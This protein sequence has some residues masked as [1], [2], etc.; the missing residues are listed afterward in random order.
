MKPLPNWAI[1]HVPHNS[2]EI[3]EAVRDQF[4]LSDL[5]LQNE[6]LKMTDHHTL[7]L[8]TRS[9]PTEQVVE[10]KVSRL[11]V[12]VERFE[13]DA[14]EVMTARGMGVI[15][16]KRHDGQPMRRN[17]SNDE[18]EQL[19]AEW[20]RPHHLALTAVVDKSIQRYGKALVIDAHSFPLLP[21]PYELDHKASRPEICIGADE[22][23]TP[24]RL[25]NAMAD[26]FIG[27]GFKVGINTPFSG[28]IVP[29]SHYQLDP[30]VLA[31][32][33]E[34]RRD[35]YMNEETGLPSTDF[36]RIA[37]EIQACISSSICEI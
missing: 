6:L 23:H 5:E 37:T 18:R 15:Y 21:L 31:V 22:F 30:R 14:Q 9:L 16:T 3:P 29:A 27:A 34:V 11:V 1:V 10:A 36:G 35:L 28:A 20:Y 12:D 4:I 8:F 24:E 25:L 33:I 19:L 2:T 13:D 17:V 26:S 32:M 7:E